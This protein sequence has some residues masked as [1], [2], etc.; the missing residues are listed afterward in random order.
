MHADN[1][2][3]EPP[4]TSVDRQSLGKYLSAATVTRTQQQI[5][6]WRRSTVCGQ[7]RGNIPENQKTHLKP[8]G[9]L[10]IY[11]PGARLKAIKKKNKIIPTEM[12]VI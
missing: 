10:H 9:M 2:T 3:E 8:Q 1:R 5:K 4:K 6:S 11:I 7:S 12:N